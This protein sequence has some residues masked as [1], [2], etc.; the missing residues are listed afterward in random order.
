MIH[1]MPASDLC[2]HIAAFLE[3]PNDAGLAEH[4]GR[5]LATLDRLGLIEPADGC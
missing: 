5:T 3:V 2:R 1:G 4:V